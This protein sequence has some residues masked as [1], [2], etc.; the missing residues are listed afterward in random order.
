M[1]V[2]ATLL[3]TLFPFGSCTVGHERNP[4]AQGVDRDLAARDAVVQ[5]S[6]TLAR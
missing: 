6:T 5:P 2:L 1:G 3:L 4:V